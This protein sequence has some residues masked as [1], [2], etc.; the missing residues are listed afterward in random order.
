MEPKTI[1]LTEAEDRKVVTEASGRGNR[2]MIVS[3]YKVLDR[4]KFFS[5]RYIA[6]HDEM[7]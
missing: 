7:E 6:E 3:G 4:R 2:K 1:E 5:L